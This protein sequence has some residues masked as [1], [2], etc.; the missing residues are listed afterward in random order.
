MSVAYSSMSFLTRYIT[1]A[2][3]NKNNPKYTNAIVVNSL[4]VELVE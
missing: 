2:K 4:S 3:K 1:I